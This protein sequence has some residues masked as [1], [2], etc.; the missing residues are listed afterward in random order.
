NDQTIDLDKLVKANET[1]TKLVDNKDGSYTYYN[2]KEIDS[3]GNEIT[4][5]GLTFKTNDGYSLSDIASYNKSLAVN[6]SYNFGE[7]VGEN[8]TSEGEWRYKPKSGVDFN[9]AIYSVS[10]KSNAQKSTKKYVHLSNIIKTTFETI[11]DFTVRK[12]S[13]AKVVVT[14]SINNQ[15]VAS[16]NE[17]LSLPLGGG[18]PILIKDTRDIEIDAVELQE[19]NNKLDIKVSVESSTFMYNKGAE[20]G[21]FAE[22]NAKLM[23]FS[24]EDLSFQLFEK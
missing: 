13:A 24:V 9:T 3:Q 6:K 5:L 22:G 4:G 14:I 23:T 16:Y 20:N 21:N 8:I 15:V 1:V 19:T 2:E 17:Y 12:N 18:D 7:I 10:F 11:N